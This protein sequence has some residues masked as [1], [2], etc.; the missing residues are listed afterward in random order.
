MASGIDVW[1]ELAVT[2]KASHAL[3]LGGN[4]V[5]MWCGASHI[6]LMSNWLSN[7]DLRVSVIDRRK[8]YLPVVLIS[9]GNRS[10]WLLNVHVGTISFITMISLKH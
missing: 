2:M 1:V 5:R 7:K 3:G 10:L 8:D 4:I 9:G 6:V